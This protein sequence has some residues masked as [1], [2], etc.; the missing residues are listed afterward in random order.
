[1]VFVVSALVVAGAAVA[2]SGSEFTQINWTPAASHP[3]GSHEGQGA[4]VG[5]KLYLFGGFDITR[6][7]CLPTPR[8]YTY[9]PAT[10]T[11]AAIR[12]LPTSTGTTYPGIT[13]SG[14]TTD[15]SSIYLAGGYVFNAT[16]T[17]QVL[18]TKDVWRYSVAAN[19]Y[20]RM[21]DLPAARGAGRLELLAGRLHYFGGA[22][23]TK[24]DR[25]D[26]WVLDLANTAAGWV[27]RASLPN[28]R[29]H[30]GSAALDGKV[31]AIGGGRGQEQS[32]VTQS[33]VHAYDYATDTWTARASLPKAIDHIADASFATGGRIIVLGGE[34][35]Y[36]QWVADVNAYDP[37]TNSWTPLTSLPT[38]RSAGL[39]GRVGNDFVYATGLFSKTTYRGVP[40]APGPVSRSVNF[41]PSQAAVPAGYEMDIGLG[42][43]AG[44]GSGWVTQASLSSATHVPTDVSAYT[45]ERNAVS[46]QR[47]DTLVHMQQ[48]GKTAA[49]WE[50]AVPSGSYTVTVSVGDA[51]YFDSTH[52]INIEGDV[53]IAGFV[54]TS[55]TRFAQATRT[56]TVS[57]GR[58]TID[59]TGGANTKL[60]YVDVRVATTADTT[61]P[62][63]PAGL[64]ATAGD[65]RVSLSWTANG[66]SDL[67][68]Y[69]VYRGTS[70]PV[71]ATGTP[72]SGSSLLT[73]PSFVDTTAANGTAY[74]YVVTAV[75]SSANASAASSPAGATPSGAAFSKA[76]NFQPSGAAVPAG[77]VKDSGL[78]FD[79]GRG[80]GWVTQASLT[81]ATHVPADVSAYMRDRDA[82]SDQRLDTLAHMQ[83]PGKTP[84]AWE[85][86]VADGTYTVTL[87]VGDQ[88]ALDS[89]HRIRIE[90]DLAIAGFV[91]TSTT[92]FA[93]VTRT[94]TVDDGR[95][96]IDA[97]GG[98][99]TKINYI[100]VASG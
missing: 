44:R 2:E 19:D 91:P 7:C 83:Y 48:A 13:H 62:A 80:F 36:N 25:G 95:L 11:W 40:V 15:G 6:A 81:S 21:P 3:F 84:A 10:N 79:S 43:D 77:Y 32:V 52:R 16:G 70:L 34:T 23:P 97:T 12:P 41:Q 68:G 26:H 1:V 86:V 24:T 74:H 64:T 67:A 63:A 31:Y 45:R 60:N 59:A 92:R 57:D 73:S 55:A 28:P 61:P 87:S 9:E 14:A 39:A 82:L 29:N 100:D 93:Q 35:G 98:T 37:V 20:T 65:G 89:T 38:A 75:D 8:A 46:D 66:E 30:L 18:G 53:A 88:A 99:N 94:V 51:A 71:A 96:T 27:A 56:V 90:D 78:G 4:V 85:L 47:L 33:S 17:N 76:V 54:P 22:D 72:L 5:G 58:L 50:L 49:A 42:F 69:R